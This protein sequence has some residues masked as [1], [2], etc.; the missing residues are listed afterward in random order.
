MDVYET[1]YMGPRPDRLCPKDNS[2]MW[3]RGYQ[4]GRSEHCA[5]VMYCPTC[6]KYYW[7]FIE[8]D[9]RRRYEEMPPEDSKFWGGR[10]CVGFGYTYSGE[11][12][13]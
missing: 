10:R 11:D 12:N 2:V 3:I 4:L 9:H 6:G 1:H 13:V 5:D 7:I 8:D